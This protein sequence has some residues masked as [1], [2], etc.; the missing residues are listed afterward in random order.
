MSPEASWQVKLAW[1]AQTKWTRMQQSQQQQQSE[2]PWVV[3]P[4]QNDKERIVMV[5][6]AYW[7]QELVAKFGFTVHPGPPNPLVNDAVSEL[8]PEFQPLPLNS[9]SNDAFVDI[10]AAAVIY[11]YIEPAYRQKRL[12]S[13]ALQMMRTIHAIQQCH[14][15][16]L[17]ADD[18]GSGKLV[19]WY[20]Q[21]QQGNFQ[22]VPP[23]LQEFLG[24][25]N[26]KY[27]VAMMALT[28]SLTA[29]GTANLPRVEWW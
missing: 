14:A 26:Q 23:Y 29:D 16:I 22:I 28:P 13:V 9:G 8:W 7:D 10:R 25:P 5:L 1:Q 20:Q 21:P 6:Q 27:G 12:G 3:L 24:N 15:T 18:N 2:L 17:V 11:M 19:Q 4:P